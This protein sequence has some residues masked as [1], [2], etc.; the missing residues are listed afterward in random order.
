[1]IRNTN[2]VDVPK[3]ELKRVGLFVK[4]SVTLTGIAKDMI[5][6]TFLVQFTQLL[7]VQLNAR[8]GIKESQ[9]D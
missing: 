1:M 2:I 6:M 9:E 8:N 5:T 4:R 3:N 7:P